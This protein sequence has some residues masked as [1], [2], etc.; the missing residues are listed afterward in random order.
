LQKLDPKSK[1]INGLIIRD[2]NATV[3]IEP[4][5]VIRGIVYPSVK[6]KLSSKAE[7]MFGLTLSA[8]TLT[9]E[10]LYGG[11]ICAALDR[12]HPRDLFD[13]KLLFE[14]EGLTDGIRKAFIVYLISHDRPIVEL[15]NPGL[16]DIKQVFENEF[17]GMTT[18]PVKLDDL[19]SVRT[20][21]IKQIKESLTEDE[22]KFLLSVKNMKPEW[23]LLGLNGIK[24]LPGIRWKLMNLQ[25]MKQGKHKLAY[26]NLETYLST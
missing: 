3:K 15:L 11:K 7:E 22:K 5:T 6:R 18:D 14:N 8:T 4:N 16:K 23:E 25:K 26:E 20:E 21:L 2:K 10:D 9:F 13:V 19:L 17:G 12:Q 24:E 1:S